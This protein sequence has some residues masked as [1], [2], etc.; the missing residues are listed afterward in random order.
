M[1]GFTMV[2]ASSYYILRADEKLIS[3][4]SS[5]SVESLNILPQIYSFF[6]NLQMNSV[7]P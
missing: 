6:L 3:P 5:E 4:Q 7:F 1:F 2:C